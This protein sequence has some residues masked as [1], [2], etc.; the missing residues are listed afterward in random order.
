M[1][2]TRSL[3]GA[4]VLGLA[5][6]GAAHADSA[7]K[8][9]T[10]VTS[11]NAQTQLMSMVLTAQ[12]VEQGAEARIL[13]CGA[14]GDIALADAPESATA[15]QP[16]RDASPQGLM[17]MLMTRGVTVEVCAIYLPGLGADKSVLIEGVGVAA[18]P[19]MG[20]AMMDEDAQVWSF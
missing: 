15:G 18:P 4:A 2:T 13:L 7:E 3:L 16:P 5:A 17:Q 6:A 19:A 8:L 1:S 12:A 11:D 14:G 9:V 10:I 20:A